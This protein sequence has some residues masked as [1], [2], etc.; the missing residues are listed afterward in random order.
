MKPK[1]L[2]ISLMVALVGGLLSPVIAPI[3]RVEAAVSGWQKGITLMPRYDWDY[4]S[5]AFKQS[6][7]NAAIANVNYVTLV[8]PYYQSNAWSTDIQRGWNTPPD[9]ALVAG[10]DYIHSK[11]MHVMLK[12]HLDTYDGQWRAQ[13]NPGDRDGWF[14]NYRTMLLHYATIAK[15]HGV[16]ELCIGSELIKMSTS[17]ENG[18]NTLRWKNLIKDVR[19]TYNGSL[20]YSANWG[21]DWFADE[22]NHIQFWDSLD[23][24]GISAYFG[25]GNDYWNNGVEYLKGEWN[26]WNNNDI[27]PLHD[28][29]NK[30]IL[31]TEIG[32]KSVTGAHTQ[33]WNYNFG[34]P[35]DEN[36]QAN[37]YEALFSY[38]NDQWWMTGVHLWDWETD[39]NAGG[40]WT[41]SYTPQNKKAQS[42]LKQWFAGSTPTPSITPTPSATPSPSPTPSN[43]PTP[44]PSPTGTPSPTPTPGPASVEV[45]WPSDG[46]HVGGTQ[47]FKAIIPNRDAYQYVMAWQVDGD[48]LNEMYTSAQDWPHKE[49]WVDLTGWTWKDDGPY[50]INF[51]AK[52]FSGAMIAQRSVDIFI[53]H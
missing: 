19:A 6:V 20:T 29:W 42:V 46:A 12:P 5:D 43:T 51:V 49:A 39:P 44:T 18:D 23:H 52:E 37:D 41:Q 14:A 17:T 35:T 7:T 24:I 22:K 26:S 31:F 10:I 8:I 27:R 30:P 47:P 45:W 50:T 13:I 53:N 1:I 3:T 2:I 38:W 40:N 11:G 28:R 9:E 21:G 16:E 4:G 34:G 33:P 32:Y 25:L 48:R 36:E 15:D